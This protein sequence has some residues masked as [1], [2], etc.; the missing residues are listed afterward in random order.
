[1]KTD[2]LGP[3]HGVRWFCA[4]GAIL[5]PREYACRSHGGGRQSGQHDARAE[6]IR[7]AGIPIANVLSGLTPDAALAND[8]QLL[9]AV[10]L[11]Q[12]LIDVDDGWILRQARYV[13][14]V[15]QAEDEMESAR[16]ILLALAQDPRS[17]GTHFAL[18]RE[19]VRALPKPFTPGSFR[20]V[21]AL[22]DEL[23]QRDDAFRDL[24]NLIHSRPSAE[25]SA[26]VRAHAATLPEGEL[27]AQFDRLAADL[28]SA[29]AHATLSERLRSTAATLADRELQTLAEHYATAGPDTDQI[30]L[31][32]R[33]IV[34]VRESMVRYPAARRVLAMEVSL[35]AEQAA[36]AA[37]RSAQSPDSLNRRERLHALAPL[38]NILYGCGLLTERE[39]AGIAAR[40]VVLDLQRSTL[41][42]YRDAV[43]ALERV[44]GWTANRLAFHFGPTVRSFARVEPR[45]R[46]LIP[47]RLRAS[48]ALRYSEILE[49]IVADADR[50]S[51]VRHE[52]F[53]SHV[54]LGLRALNPGLARG[55][56]MQLDPA[57]PSRAAAA[58]VLVPETVSELP[59]VAGILTEAEGNELSH[60]QLLARN[61]GLPNVVVDRRHL[62]QLEA[63][64]GVSIVVAASPGGIVRITRDG[65]QWDTW[66]PAAPSAPKHIAVD[67][68][69]LDLS[70][71]APIPLD[72]LRADDAGR[73]VGPK[74]A[75][76]GELSNRYPGMVAPGLAIPFGVYRAVLDQPAPDGTQ[77]M[78]AWMQAQHCRLAGIEDA[79]ER[80]A[81][82]TV[83]L[84]H[85]RA[86]FATVAL[87]ADLVD[88]LRV[89]TPQ[90]FGADG[91]YVRSDTNLEDL[92]GFT[93]AGLNRTVPNVVG[94][95]KVLSAIREV[96]ASPYTERA[97]GWRQG[98][99]DRPEHV[100]VSVLLQRAVPSEKSGVMVTADPVSGDAG[101]VLIAV[102]EGAGGAVDGQSVESLRLRLADERVELLNSATEPMRRETVAGGGLRDVPAS[103]NPA[104]LMPAER[105]ALAQVART[106]PQRYPQLRDAENRP[107]PADVEFAFAGGRLYLMQ[108]RPFL[109]ST[110]AQ[111]SAYLRQLDAGVAPA[112]DAFVDLD[113]VP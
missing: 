33:I 41:S 97:Y 99:M 58:I 111:R 19:A 108:I 96:W 22:A 93:G 95:D 50:L 63:H 110:R 56:L 45:S 74:A 21:R 101:Y 68:G 27:R 62:P 84:E 29:F 16:R 82:S 8:A 12:F 90:T 103:G 61:L 32:A 113:A 42:E 75:N 107:A 46:A 6:A 98:V 89:L 40:L 106:I 3:F 10:L 77:S 53:G 69:R 67:P 112:A 44:P 54:V 14:G 57:H 4:D 39:R 17:A 87:P 79:A 70:Q 60:V 26:R 9:K 5:P 30:A 86:W 102:N 24:R 35:A 64:I 73:I 7:A 47:D 88:S 92:P 81:A 28:D 49:P 31:L 104:V 34:R 13:R 94:F 52:L 66:F 91:I 43:T 100:Y 36:F 15:T 25:L 109:H 71:R 23:A 85:V 72:S 83:F 18:L 11:E 55:T 48:V 105:R 65:P 51:S 76:L 20:E 2:A 1:M 38:V 80:K 78:F 59:A 37:T